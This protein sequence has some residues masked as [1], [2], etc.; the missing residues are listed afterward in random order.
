[1]IGNIKENKL[2]DLVED[3]AMARFGKAK[4]DTLP[5]LC[6]E[7]EVLSSCNGG[8]PKD[9]V[10]STPDGE[11]GLNYFCLAYKAF[12]IHTRPELTRLAEHMKAG[13]KLREFR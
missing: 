12:F 13:K 4:R 7:C 3:P 6:K 1:L 11:A 9:R 2:L 8:C 5:R 10:D